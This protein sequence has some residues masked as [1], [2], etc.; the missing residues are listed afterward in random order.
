MVER[1]AKQYWDDSWKREA[2]L[3]ATFDPSVAGIRGLF[4]RQFHAFFVEQ[5]R[6]IAIP[7]ASLIEIGCGRSQLLPYFAKHFRLRVSGLDY[8][9]VGCDKARRILERERIPGEIFCGDLRT[10]DAFPEPGYDLV[11]S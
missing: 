1:V 10:F 7:E 3:P 11:F 2:Q 5:F 6:D 4:R 8:S 9:A